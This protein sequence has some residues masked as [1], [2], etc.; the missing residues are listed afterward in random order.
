MIEAHTPMAQAFRDIVSQHSH[1]EALVCGDV[2]VTYG[3][4]RERVASLAYGL[5]ELGIG[6]GDRVA[7]FLLPSVEF[8][9]LF[10]ALAE[11]GAVIVPLNPQPVAVPPPPVAAHPPGFGARG[12]GDL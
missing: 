10:F 3:Q 6:K 2:R 9:T 4:L 1:R 12:C 7:T 8:V 5:H 11:L